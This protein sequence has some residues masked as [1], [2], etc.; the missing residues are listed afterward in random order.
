MEIGTQVP[1]IAAST[2][3]AKPAMSQIDGKPYLQFQVTGEATGI[4]AKEKDGQTL[5]GLVGKFEAI[6]AW[7]GEIYR[8]GVAY[9]PSGIHELATSVLLNDANSVVQF[10][11]EVW[12]VPAANPRGYSWQ[13]KEMSAIATNDPLQHIKARRLPQ[14]AATAKKLLAINA[15]TKDQALLEGDTLSAEDIA[16]MKVVSGS[17][18]K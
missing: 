5:F 17:K 11:L 15:G 18:G 14:Y 8:S 4:V 7:T 10:D 16:D 9:L 13:A 12:S 1:K 3:G 2:I 6:N